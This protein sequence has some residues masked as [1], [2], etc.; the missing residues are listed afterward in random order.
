MR[1]R[2]EFRTRHT[3]EKGR[4]RAV[5]AGW[6]LAAAALVLVGTSFVVWQT[7]GRSNVAK[8]QPATP[9]N[10][11]F[12][13]QRAGTRRTLSPKTMATNSL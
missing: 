3:T 4:G 6:L 9:A 12:C 11:S 13:G 8:Q 2:Q 7:G 10:R 5:V 1:L